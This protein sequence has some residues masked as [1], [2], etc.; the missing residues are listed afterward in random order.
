VIQS[1]QARDPETVARMGELL[2]DS[3]DA[4]AIL[5]LGS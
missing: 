1:D 3:A 5:G 2:A 4:D